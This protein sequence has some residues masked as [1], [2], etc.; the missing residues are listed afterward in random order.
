MNIVVSVALLLL[1][2]PL[3]ERPGIGTIANATV[4]G[5]VIDVVLQV[6]QAPTAMWA[7]VVLLLLGPVLSASGPAS[8]SASVRA[9]PRDGLMTGLAR[10]GWPIAVAR[11]TVEATALAIGWALGGRVGVGTILFAATIGPL[12]H[13]T[14]PRLRLPDVPPRRAPGLGAAR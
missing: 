7:R 2:I 13:L 11:T 10:R 6:A 8:T 9:G 12:V 1:W 3:G 5:V 14:L 4:I